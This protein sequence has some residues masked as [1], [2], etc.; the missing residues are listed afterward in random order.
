MS[1]FTSRKFVDYW[2]SWHAQWYVN[3]SKWIKGSPTPSVIN[4]WPLPL[5]K[6]GNHITDKNGIYIWQ[7]FPEPY[8]GNPLS[9]T[10]QAVFVNLNPGEGGSSQNIKDPGFLFK[11]YKSYYDAI[12]VSKLS[13]GKP[14]I[15]DEAGYCTTK[16]FKSNRANKAADIVC[17]LSGNNQPAVQVRDI[18]CL[19]MV[20]W[21]TSSS[22][23]L[24]SYI[25]Q[26]AVQSKI[27]DDVILNASELA[28]CVV[29]PLKNIVLI[30]GT[31]AMKLKD[32]IV[33]HGGQFQSNCNVTSNNLRSW[34]I[35]TA[36]LNGVTFYI[37]TGPRTNRLPNTKLVY[38]IIK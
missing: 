38:D 29:S 26:P 15:E 36:C 5:D 8:W 24:N 16:W 34:K 4:G 14:L 21:H 20:P 2:D 30:R 37:F 23:Q 33:R 31:W 10:L 3:A 1:Q 22:N 25:C 19:E 12:A 27:F 17:C 9:K 6:N 35:S 13:N 11:N 18:V 28:K 32:E 7:Y